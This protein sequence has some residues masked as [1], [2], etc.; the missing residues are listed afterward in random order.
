[1]EFYSYWRS[2]AAYRVRIA[3]AYKGLTADTRY[4][5]LLRDGGEHRAAGYQSLNPAQLVPVLV[6]GDLKLNQSLAILEYLEALH[7]TPALL[8]KNLKLAMQVR[9]VALDIAC[10]IHPLNNLRVLQYLT[11][12]LGL[13]EQQKLHWIQHWLQQGLQA[14]ELRLQATASSCCFG[15]DVTWADI[16]LVPQ[17]YNAVRFSLDMSAYPTLKRIYQHCTSL[18]AFI[19]ASP[20]QQP[21]AQ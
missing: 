19:K 8:P 16:C 20:E 5:H 13:S 21:D 2:S 10:D 15:D 14:L 18:P 9:A 1:M 7:P 12:P 17:I 11:G 6:D 3:L 4:V